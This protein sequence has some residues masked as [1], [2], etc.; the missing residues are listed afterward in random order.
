MDMRLS[1]LI[2]EL[3]ID[4]RLDGDMLI[5]GVTSDTRTKLGEGFA[6]VCIKGGTFDGH[7]AAADMV[8]RGAAVVFCERDLGL[9]NQIIV[10]DS[11]RITFTGWS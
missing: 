10:E 6:F 9:E 1:E 11:R 7:T 2:K 3:D 8:S 4:T 5:T